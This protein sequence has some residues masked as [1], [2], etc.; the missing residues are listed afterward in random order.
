MSGLKPE[1]MEKTEAVFQE[2]KNY[3]VLALVRAHPEYQK[4]VS[5]KKQLECLVKNF[6][7]STQ[8]TG[9]ERLK[10]VEVFVGDLCVVF[11]AKD[12]N[13]MNSGFR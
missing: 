4:K 7:K 5:F 2:L 1:T 12:A 6:F 10:S 8:K 11:S 13:A 9:E 3:Y